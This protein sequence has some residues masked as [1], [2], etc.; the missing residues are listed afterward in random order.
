MPQHLLE[1]LSLPSRYEP[2][3]EEIGPE[4]LRLLMKPAA[5]TMHV[6]EEAAEAVKTTAEGVFLPIYAVPGT[7]KTTLAENLF[8]FLAGSYTKTL[9]YT[10]EITRASLQGALEA[11]LVDVPPNETRAVPINI[12][13]REGRGATPAELAEMKGFLRKGIGRR[14]VVIW[15]ETDEA[16]AR[17]MSA[18]FRAVSGALPLDIPVGVDG[19]PPAA[20]ADLAAQ[21]L[22]LAN[23]VDSIEQLVD[24]AAYDPAAYPSIGDY[25]RSIGVDFNS[26]RLELQRATVRPVQLTILWVTSTSGHGILSSLTSSTRFG[27]LDASALLQASPGTA[28][29][30]WW[31]ERRGLLIQTILSLE[32]HVLS[33]SPPLSVTVMRRYG[34]VVV[35]QALQDLGASVRGPSEVGDYISR[36]DLGR[37]LAGEERSVAEGR[38]NPGDAGLVFKIFAEQIGFSAGK[39]KQINKAFAQAVEALLSTDGQSEVDVR[40]EKALDFLPS[41]IPDLSIVTDEGAHCLE[42]TYRKGDDFLG[43]K[44]RATI[45]EYCLNKLRNYAVSLGWAQ[46]SA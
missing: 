29:G 43:S 39:D 12:D 36:S 6:L 23:K 4:V 9:T 33:V 2:L 14:A 34:P 8:L 7:G 17:E 32:A 11:F 5:S 1:T 18:R 42:F 21:T 13:D 10:G 15:P 30:A 20:W 35:Q 37:R 31:A 16:L 26:K 45:A 25:L 19:P 24:L 27:M 40:H 46:R 22:R 28:V 3:V 41:L 38:G 44:Y